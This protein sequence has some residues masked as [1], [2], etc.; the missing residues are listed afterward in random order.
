[1]RGRADVGEVKKFS[2]SECHLQGT[3][4]RNAV[5]AAEVAEVVAL[6]AL[7]HPKKIDKIDNHDGTFDVVATF[8]PCADGRP[9]NQPNN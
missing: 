9:S 3:W 5:P 6:D 4:T 2:F 1:M 7:D 8:P